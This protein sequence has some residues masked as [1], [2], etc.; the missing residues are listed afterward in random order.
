MK[1]LLHAIVILTRISDLKIRDTGVQDTHRLYACL[2]QAQGS[3][4]EVHTQWVRN[5]TVRFNS[6]STPL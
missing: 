5:N 6:R 3:R 2:N 4:E 1:S